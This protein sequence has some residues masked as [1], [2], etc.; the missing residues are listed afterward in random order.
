MDGFYDLDGRV[1]W[2]MNGGLKCYAHSI[3]ASGLHMIC[4]MYERILERMPA[5][6]KG[7]I[8][9]DGIES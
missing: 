7:T 2:Y 3:G 4:A 8:S 1:P 9:P 6:R 5:E